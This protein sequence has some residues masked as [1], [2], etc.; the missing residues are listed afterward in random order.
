MLSTLGSKTGSSRTLLLATRVGKTVTSSSRGR[1][2]TTAK[3]KN[4]IRRPRP[5]PRASSPYFSKNPRPDI[6]FRWGTSEQRANQE[7]EEEGPFDRQTEHIPEGIPLSTLEVPYLHVLEGCIKLLC[8]VPIDPLWASYPAT[9][10]GKLK[11]RISNADLEATKK[12]KKDKQATSKGGASSQTDKGE[13]RPCTMVAVEPSALPIAIPSGDSPPSKRQ[14]CSSPP[15]PTQDKGK[16]TQSS[17]I[18]GLEDNSTI[19]SDT[20]LVGPIM[21]SLTTRHD[22]TGRSVLTSTASC[23]A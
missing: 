7:P 3:R 8:S 1:A 16:E 6:A 23:S 17:S 14:R 4:V 20:A 12:K 18:L 9:D 13:E 11:M 19:R 15:A 5:R 22:R 21:D 10:M 2:P